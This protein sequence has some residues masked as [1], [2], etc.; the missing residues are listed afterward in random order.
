MIFICYAKCL[1]F[2]IGEK[3]W[4]RCQGMSDALN[5]RKESLLSSTSF[6]PL[7]DPCLLQFHHV[8]RAEITSGS[9][10]EVTK[11]ETLLTV[12]ESPVTQ[13]LS[14]ISLEKHIYDMHKTLLHLYFIQQII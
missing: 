3:L 5:L 8:N 2:T 12:S 9:S 13:L 1:G 10:K 14:D 4:A 11:L 7:K 6:V